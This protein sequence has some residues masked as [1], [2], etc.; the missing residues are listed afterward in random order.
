[1][2][3]RAQICSASPNAQRKTLQIAGF[4]TRFTKRLLSRL[5]G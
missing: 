4:R 1:M 5:M 2:Q 3:Q